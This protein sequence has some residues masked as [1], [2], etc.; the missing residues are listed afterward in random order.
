[1][2]RIN[3][4]LVQISV[5][6]LVV[7]SAASA[8]AGDIG[9]G[10]FISPVVT[11]FDGLTLLS[12]GNTYPS[13]INGN[14]FTGSGTFGYGLF[15]STGDCFA[16]EC[17][18]PDSAEATMTITLGT[19]TARAGL[20]LGVSDATVTFYDASDNVLDSEAVDPPITDGSNLWIG[21]ESDS[22]LISSITITG[23]DAFHIFTIDNLTTDSDNDPSTPEPASAG[24]ALLGLSTVFLAGKK[25]RANVA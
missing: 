15:G 22:D 16:N 3:R 24:L 11:T 18:G 9:P 19:A 14:T 21:W 10:D 2:R 1:M 25:Y 7:I 6:A 12:T 17:I 4:L 5:P 23:D 20:Y 8:Y 13:V